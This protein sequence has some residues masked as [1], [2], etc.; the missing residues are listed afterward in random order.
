MLVIMLRTFLGFS[1]LP[2]LRGGDLHVVP[3]TDE[4]IKAEKGHLSY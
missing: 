3:F 4:I 1:L 2:T